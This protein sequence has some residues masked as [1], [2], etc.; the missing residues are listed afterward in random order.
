MI[1]HTAPMNLPRANRLRMAEKPNIAEITSKAT[2]QAI[3]AAGLVGRKV[4]RSVT[5]GIRMRKYAVRQPAAMI[6][7]PDHL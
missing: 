2:S 5:I 3:T 1:I 7:A 4:S 6:E